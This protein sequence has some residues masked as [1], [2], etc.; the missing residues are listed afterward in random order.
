[1]EI[2]K[3]RIE[4]EFGIVPLLT[5][6]QVLYKNDEQGN[7]IE[8]YMKLTI[9]APSQYIGAVMSLLQTQK[10]NLTNLTYQG[11]D[12]I[13]EYEIPYSMFIRGL[14]A[15]IKSVSSGFASF[16]YELLDYKKADLV[17]LEILING[18]SID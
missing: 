4:R 1:A 12:A 18:Q 5:R 2:V 14:S 10:A 13:L 9:Y 15:K 7:L 3:D 16:D 11:Q 6:P 8:P 17:D